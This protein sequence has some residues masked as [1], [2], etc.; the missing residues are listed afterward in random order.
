MGRGACGIDP[1]DESELFRLSDAAG[2]SAE[3]D[4]EV[5]ENRGCVRRV[6]ALD[7]AAYCWL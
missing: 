2:E 6:C 3:L 5:S 4:C 1:C 7:V